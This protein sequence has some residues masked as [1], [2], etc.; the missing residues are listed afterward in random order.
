MARLSD[1]TRVDQ[2]LMDKIQSRRDRLFKAHN[3]RPQLELTSIFKSRDINGRWSVRPESPV[4]I[5]GISELRQVEE[6][7]NYAS[8]CIQI[9]TVRHLRSWT[10]LDISYETI[11]HLLAAHNVFDHFW[12]CIL[13]FGIKF[14]E[15]EY[16]FPPFRA[17][18][19]QNTH[20]RVDELA[21][22]IRRV[23]PNNSP[24]DRGV[25]P[26]SIR[27]TGVYHKMVYPNRHSQFSIRSTSVFILI[28]PSHAAE[29]SI[30]YRL[31]EN[32]SQDDTCRQDFLIHECI[33]RDSLK[34]WMDYQAWLEAESKQIANRVLVLDILQRGKNGEP[35]SIY[36]SAEDRQRLKHLEDYITDML[37]ILQTMVDSISRIGK[38]CRRHCQTSCNGTGSCLCSHEI[39]GFD[40]CAAEAQTSL[41]RAKVLRERVQSTEQLC[42]HLSDLLA[43]EEAAA[44]TQLA[45]ASRIESEE[46]VKLAA[47]S[48]RDAAAVKVLTIIGLVYLPTTIVSVRVDGLSPHY[49]RA[50]LDR[51]SSSGLQSDRSI[52]RRS[53]L[54]VASSPFSPLHELQES[55]SSASIEPDSSGH[56]V[57][58]P[59]SSLKELITESKVED[60]LRE[61]G[62]VQ[63]RN[64]ETEARRIVRTSMKLFAILVS[65]K[66]GA[67]ILRFLDEGISDTDLPFFMKP[68]RTGSERMT[69]QTNGGRDIKALSEWTDPEIKS[70]AKKQWRMLAPVFEQGK[71]YDFPVAQILPFTNSGRIEIES[72]FSE[73]FQAFIHPA[74]H[75]FRNFP[76]CRDRQAVVAVKKLFSFDPSRF[77]IERDMHMTLR[78]TSGPHPHLISLLFTYKE[79]SKFH[80]VF[81][82]ADVNLRNYWKRIP[83]EQIDYHKVLWSLKQMT[84]LASALSLIHG[85]Q[86][87]DDRQPGRYFGRHG[88]LKA[89]NIVWFPSYPGCTDSDG[90]LQITDLGLASLHSIGSVSNG[91]PA[92]MLGT[93]TYRPPDNHR[94]LRIS[95]KWDIWSLGCLYLEFITW[96]VLGFD[97]I[98]EFAELRGAEG[99]EADEFSEDY[100]YTTDLRGIRPSVKAWVTR[101]SEDERCSD[102]LYDLLCLIMWKMI[103]IEPNDRIDSQQLHQQLLNLLEQASSNGTY[104]VRASERSPI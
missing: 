56:V 92:G 62:L 35:R 20:S 83:L 52:S 93:K 32:V 27:Q 55:L 8:S 40:E 101:L 98:V 64:A 72:G 48:A 42:L 47:R 104:L 12:R 41:N 18:N 38:A 43:Y 79:G 30:A 26:W 100:F 37:V 6:T 24:T 45:Y 29:K 89:E 70:L 19:E 50:P 9:Y 25:C 21:Y 1:Q 67:D 74:H 16:D 22:V 103:R 69:L 61:E 39:E 23:E 76:G 65:R 82:W 4:K 49:P 58:V 2:Y 99:G 60:I 88:D 44:L 28:A 78:K 10:T 17:N 87:P 34:G 53:S 85:F 80:L 81:P 13:T 59:L 15:N 11:E 3:N 36:V 14:Q 86:L 102:M 54:D 95:R 71:H 97:A 5:N 91:D 57:Y 73:V 90:I 31:P 51:Q 33:V 75:T 46:M 66:R 84:G 77:Q 96:I 68:A 7:D 63:G 94:N